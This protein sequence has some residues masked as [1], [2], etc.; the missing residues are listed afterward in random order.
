MDEAAALVANRSDGD[1]AD[2]PDVALDPDVAVPA[3]AV[4]SPAVSAIFKPPAGGEAV[5]PAASAAA[6]SS[7]KSVVVS[8][9]SAGGEADIGGGFRASSG[10]WGKGK[11]AA[12]GGFFVAGARGK[13]KTGRAG[14]R[15]RADSPGD[16]K[17][18]NGLGG[19]AGGGKRAVL[20]SQAGMRQAVTV[21]SEVRVAAP[22]LY[23][24]LNPNKIRNREDVGVSGGGRAQS[25]RRASR[26]PRWG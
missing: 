14:A 10:R 11:T 19:G 6:V 8:G 22:G 5:S 23:S 9:G 4:A 25:A 13:G 12:G 20:V 26:Q 1:V 24:S 16:H 3:A 21:K 18:Q 2:D 17:Q 15:A 7:V